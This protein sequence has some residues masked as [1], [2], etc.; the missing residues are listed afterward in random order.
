[1]KK[2]IPFILIL[3]CLAGL[4]GG[5]YF[6]TTI[7]RTPPVIVV[8]RQN[9][10]QYHSGMTAAELLSGV[11]AVDDK[12]GDVSA[13]LYVESVTAAQDPSQVEVIYTATDKSKNVARYSCLIPSDGSAV[14]FVPEAPS[15][16]AA[17]DAGVAGAADSF[18]SGNEEVQ[19]EG[20]IDAEVQTEPQEAASASN[21]QGDERTQEAEAAISMLSSEAPVIRLTKYY[22]EILH[23]T[24]MDLMYYVAELTDDVDS[25]DDLIAKLQVFSDVNIDVPGTYHVTYYTMDSDGHQSNVAVL[26]VRVL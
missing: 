23:G 8:M 21:G 14:D 11:T 18:V 7:D 22:E 20:N 1:M 19:T 6:Y 5:F 25:T 26:E 4:A 9:D 16:A 12:S 3:L 2:I 17:S 13:T 24:E 10:L 15:A